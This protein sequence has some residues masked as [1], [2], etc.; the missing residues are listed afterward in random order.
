[1][2]ADQKKRFLKAVEQLNAVLVD[3]KREYPEKMWSYYLAGDSL[4]LMQGESHDRHGKAQ[5]QNSAAFARL[6]SSGGGDW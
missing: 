6:D 5:R 4:H 2:N 3:V 1:M